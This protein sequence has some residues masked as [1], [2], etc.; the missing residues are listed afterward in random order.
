MYLKNGNNISA[1]DITKFIMAIMVVGIHTL[2]KYGIYPLFRM[3]VP[4]F[5]MMS[6]YLFFKNLK[7][8]N[9]KEYLKKFCRR[10]IK[11]YIF[12]FIAL[13]PIFLFSGG[14]LEGNVVLNFI[15]LGARII[16]GSS[17][18]A[19]WYISAL[20][21]GVCAVFFLKDRTNIY[22][23]LVVAFCAYAICCLN[24][25]YRNLFGNNSLITTINEIYP[26][27]IYNGFP[28]GLVW[29]GLGYTFS[30]K[31]NKLGI[32]QSGV[33]LL[34]SFLLLLVEDWAVKKSGLVVDNDCYFMLI[35]TCYFSFS[36]L[37]KCKW[38]N[39]N[40]KILRKLSTVIYCVHGSVATV[41][42]YYLIQGV[43]KEDC[44]FKFLIVL[45]LSLIISIVICI[46]GKHKWFRWLKLA[47]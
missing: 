29:I 24:S 30:Y 22:F 32:L 44:I 37:L 10:N 36:C 26:G 2:G 28:V 39:E 15:K 21:I 47:Y 35:P 45:L 17:F 8:K 13:S 14:Y 34:V 25:N 41:I 38:S 40:T 11:L 31:E 27:T 7:G 6:S 46:L 4:L 33:G 3:A 9:E 19:S 12:W 1:F 42:S 20:V 43:E 16:F 5:F 23:I 18:V